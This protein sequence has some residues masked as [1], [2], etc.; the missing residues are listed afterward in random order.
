MIHSGIIFETT[1]AEA[2]TFTNGGI[3][4]GID[5]SHHLDHFVPRLGHASTAGHSSSTDSPGN[6]PAN[7]T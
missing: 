5:R 7:G 6:Y 1:W 4:V 3:I 2:R